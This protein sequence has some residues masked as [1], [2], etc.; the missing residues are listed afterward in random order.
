MRTWVR[1]PVLTVLSGLCQLDGRLVKK[2][3]GSRYMIKNKIDT[4]YMN[5][6]KGKV[7]EQKRWALIWFI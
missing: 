3:T 4:R 7:Y 1:F 2:N 5:Q 6:I